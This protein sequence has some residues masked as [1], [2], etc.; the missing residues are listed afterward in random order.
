MGGKADHC[1]GYQFNPI[2]RFKFGWYRISD[3][4]VLP[5]G[6]PISACASHII[7]FSI[8]FQHADFNLLP[9]CLCF[10]GAEGCR[11]S[12]SFV[13][14]GLDWLP[15]H[16]VIKIRRDSRSEVERT[17]GRPETG[18]VSHQGISSCN[19]WAMAVQRIWPPAVHQGRVPRK[20]EPESCDL[21]WSDFHVKY[22]KSNPPSQRSV[23]PLTAKVVIS[24]Y[25]PGQPIEAFNRTWQVVDHR[26]VG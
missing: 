3:T 15:L 23:L 18:T 25:L 1:F 17:P 20:P 22:C 16:S 2:Q 5:C 21:R 6:E 12:E 11:I 13:S 9:M 10:M 19:M 8:C 26:I 14:I 4:I 24:C 7:A